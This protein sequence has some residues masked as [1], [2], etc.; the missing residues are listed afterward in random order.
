MSDEYRLSDIPVFFSEMLDIIQ[1]VYDHKRVRV[2]VDKHPWTLKYMSYGFS[3]A[4]QLREFAEKVGF[5]ITLQVPNEL[6]TK[7][8]ERHGKTKVIRYETPLGNARQFVFIF[9]CVRGDIY[10]VINR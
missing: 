8:R 7:Y 4:N 10:K 1:Q 3:E 5:Q 6:E 2:F 9:E